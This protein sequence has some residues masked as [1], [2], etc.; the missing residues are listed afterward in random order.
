MATW[1][2]KVFWEIWQERKHQCFMCW[3]HIKEPLAWCFAH[4]CWKWSYP[5]QRLNKENIA[6]VCSL[7]CHKKLDL[8]TAKVW[9]PYLSRMYKEWKSMFSILKKELWK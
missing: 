9:K 6:L 5:K 4:I 8:L 3:K 7:D 2:K 1:E